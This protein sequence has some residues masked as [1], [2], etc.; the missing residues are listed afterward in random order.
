MM[1][2]YLVRPPNHR[3][4]LARLSGGN[5]QKVLLA[6][7]II[8]AAT[9]VLILHEPT[10]GVDVGA[11]RELLNIIDRLAAE[12][13]AVLI[14]STDHEDLLNACD[15]M[16]VLRAGAGIVLDQAATALTESEVLTACMGQDQSG[17]LI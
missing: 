10:Q 9:K 1:R 12:G 7:R 17:S 5:Q 16:I 3:L 15:R 14:M 6:S 8:P 4:Q 13:T 11:K 2:S